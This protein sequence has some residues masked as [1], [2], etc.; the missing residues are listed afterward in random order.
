VE[1]ILLEHSRALLHDVGQDLLVLDADL[2][3]APYGNM[4]GEG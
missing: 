2:S 1:A 4:A 3:P